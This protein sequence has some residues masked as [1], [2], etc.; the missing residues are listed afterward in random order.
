MV[1]NL[2][3]SDN[4][5]IKFTN[6]LRYLLLG[7][8]KGLRTLYLVYLYNLALKQIWQ[9]RIYLLINRLIFGQKYIC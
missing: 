7:T 3:N 9:F 8:G 2:F 1:F 4:S 6:T 5:T